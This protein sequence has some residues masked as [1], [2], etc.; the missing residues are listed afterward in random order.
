VSIDDRGTYRARFGAL[1]LWPALIRQQDCRLRVGK[2]TAPTHDA[3][4]E[5][6]PALG[7]DRMYEADVAE[8]RAAAHPLQGGSCPAVH[9]RTLLAYG[10]VAHDWRLAL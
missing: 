10:R 9:A 6:G 5:L 8:L 2:T 1:S 3:P 4:L 7:F